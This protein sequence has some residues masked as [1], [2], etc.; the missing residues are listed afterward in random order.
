MSDKAY[1]YLRF[2][3]PD[4]MEGDSFRRQTAAAQEYAQ[5]HGL[6]LDDKLTFNDL[7]VS[8][9][10]GKNAE[11]G[12]LAEFLEAVR[13]GLVE[14]GATLLV[15][16]LDRISRQSARKALRVLE[17]ICDEGVT[18]VTLSDG[19][20]YTREALDSDPMALIMSILT[21][22]RAN[23]ESAMKAKRVREAWV[24]KRAKALASGAAITANGPWWLELGEDGQWQVIK[25]R[26]QVLRWAMQRLL[27]GA[28][29]RSITREITEQG[30]LPPKNGKRWY[31]A[32]LRRMLTSP[33]LIGTF[34]P[35][36]TVYVG[37][38]RKR[39]QLDPIP[40]YFPAI[41][42]D[43]EWTRLQTHLKP[44]RRTR[45]GAPC[46][47]NLLRGLASCAHC[48][49]PM[50]WIRRY[51]HKQ[52]TILVCAGGKE[53]LGICRWR[54]VHYDRV[55]EA[56][57]RESSHMLAHVPAG[58]ASLDEEL[59]R[60]EVELE[61]LEDAIGRTLRRLDRVESDS[62]V[63]H[64][65]ELEKDRDEL[66]ERLEALEEQ[67]RQASGPLAEH[68][69]KELRALLRA[70]EPDR[71]AINAALRQV[72]SDVKVDADEGTVEFVWRHGGSATLVVPKVGR[73]R[74]QK[75][76]KA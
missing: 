64:L 31:D 76:Q 56:F 71:M 74:P 62:L 26:A 12:R 43:D 33:A 54:S 13:A 65:A 73:G 49:A 22:L 37:R 1:S 2:S 66:K 68:R 72:F 21:F 30:V 53:A 25:E 17:S 63:A 61:A 47:G 70:D 5:K 18:L 15:E 24:G 50:R 51:A 48:G 75:Q 39:R 41:L 46:D 11:T 14:P 69:V 40:G 19:R 34:Q 42:S 45:G 58:D 27:K 59:A 32:A 28:T 8:A 67:Q 55:E 3:T 44:A 38:A 16:N 4:Q 23:E 52:P 7:G 9:F 57:L 35:G 20:A 10:R 60:L 6:E 29:F 36:E